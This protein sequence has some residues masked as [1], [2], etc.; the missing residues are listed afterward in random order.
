MVLDWIS[1]CL[2]PGLGLAGF[3]RLVEHFGSPGRVLAASQ[4]EL[5]K[6]P[7]IQPRQVGALA[8]PKGLRQRGST[9]LELL[10]K[11]NCFAVDFSD[12]SYPELLRQIADPPPVL[13][14]RGCKELLHRNSL[15]IVGSRASTAYGR[16]TARSLAADLAPYLTIVSGMALGIDAEAH[17]GALAA[18]GGTIAVLGC[19]LDVIYPMQNR[20]LYE[21]IGQSGLLVTEYPFGTSPEGFRFPARNRIIAGL[22]LGVL[23]VEAA[24]KSGSL[25]T[26]EMA[27]ES[28]REVFAVPG[29]VDS[30]KSEGTHWLLKEGA[31][32]VQ[33]ARDVLEE[34]NLAADS[35][36]ANGKAAD[37]RACSVDPE[38]LQLLNHIEPYPQARERLCNDSGLTAARINELLLLLE[39][40]GLI[41]M[42][43]GDAV[44]RLC[45]G[46]V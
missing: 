46:D 6:V 5:L 18:G 38:A 36:S 1:L 31:K 12:V 35:T 45:P 30:F 3:W 24:R 20:R 29:Q 22:S 15:A 40:E 16:R 32:L 28:G 39:L 25:I 44:R 9:E 7:G 11:K 34:L 33:S 37:S 8:C 19:G 17:G 43:P 13:F 21:Q 14:L 23:V 2:A 41:E 42:L 10:L 26:A 4:T 27:L